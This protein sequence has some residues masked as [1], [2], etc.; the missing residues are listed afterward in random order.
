MKRFLLG[1]VFAVFATTSSAEIYECDFKRGGSGGWIP[2]N[3]FLNVDEEANTASVQDAVT[4]SKK[5]GWYD[6]RISKA[7]AKRLTVKWTVDGLKDTRGQN[8]VA[9][10]TLTIVRAK[11]RANA[12]MRPRSYDNTWQTAGNC[13]IVE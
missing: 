2:L 8:V 13:K 9:D 10:Y 5:K 6:G 3:V 12:I 7:N 1:A 4:R 11:M